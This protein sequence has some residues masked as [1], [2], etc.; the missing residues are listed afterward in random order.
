LVDNIEHIESTTYNG[1]DVVKAYL[2]PGASIDTANAQITAIS[3]FIL[4][5][6]PPGEQPPQIINFSASSVPVL[7]LGM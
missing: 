3:Q 1:L 4:R 2:Q 5:Q 7:Q 6:L